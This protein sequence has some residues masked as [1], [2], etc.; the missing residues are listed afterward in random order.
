MDVS[1]V[2]WAVAALAIAA[3]AHAQ[4]AV[5]LRLNLHFYGDNTE[6]HNPFR[7]GE[8]LFGVT[9]RLYAD[10]TMTERLGVALG[11]AVNRRF[12]DDRG[13]DVIEPLAALV[14][15]GARS[16]FVMGSLDAPSA[17]VGLGPD[18]EGPHGLLPP[19]QRETLSFERPHEAGL[20]WAFEAPRARQD[21]WINWQRRN[22]SS[23][24]ERF[25]A[26]VIGRISLRRPLSLA[27]EA[28]VVHHGGQLFSSGPVADSIAAAP[29]VVADGRG[30]TG[31]L[32]GVLSRYVPD[33][34]D[35]VRARTGIAFLARAA[36]A[37]RGW[38]GHL[39]VWRACDYIKEEGDANYLSVRQDG[40]RYRGTRDYSEIGVARTFALAPGARLEA[41]ARF[42]RA[43]KNYDYS[44]RIVA[45]TD[46]AWRVHQ[47]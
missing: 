35:L 12:G 25:D 3:P 31:E 1:R 21:V 16:R 2:C 7:D 47:R 36:I 18:R 8:T 45:V 33:R 29:G 20:L 24:R 46:L 15:R 34:E 19:L 23:H 10:L 13:F 22:T 5:D 42:H 43:E 27:Y 26:G 11:I 30:I 6:F 28:H 38:R 40:S 14:I 9:G 37:R 44:Y 41:S 4:D 17:R 32:Y 39:I